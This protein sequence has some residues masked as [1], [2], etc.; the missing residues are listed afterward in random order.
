MHC[1]FFQMPSPKLH[2]KTS[3]TYYSSAIALLIPTCNI[4]A[5]PKQFKQL[6]KALFRKNPQMKFQTLVS[7]QFFIHRASVMLGLQL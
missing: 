1:D 3:P 7:Y 2:D 6:I 4:K 5:G